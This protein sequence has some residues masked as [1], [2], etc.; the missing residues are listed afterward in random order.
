MNRTGWSALVLSLLVGCGQEEFALPQQSSTLLP[1]ADGAAVYALNVDEGTVA[2]MSLGADRAVELFDAGAE[3]TRL[4]RGGGRV[5]VTLRGERSVVAFDEGAGKLTETARSE[6]GAEP[7]G[8]V[9]TADGSRVYVAISMEDRVVEL[10]GSTL[11]ELRTWTVLDEPRWLALTHD[12]HQ[13]YV[14]SARDGRFTRIDLESGATA[15]V[16]L[17][18]VGPGRGP[19]PDVGGGVV[20]APDIDGMTDLDLLVTG[21]PAISADG[22][23]LAIPSVYADT[24]TPVDGD[25]DAGR[26]GGY[27]SSGSGL[28]LSRFNPSLILLPLD[29]AG[30]PLVDEAK[31]VFIGVDTL[32]DAFRSYPSSATADTTGRY[33]VVPLEASNVAVV[34]DSEPF[35]GQ[36]DDEPSRK[37]KEFDGT[38][39]VQM[40]FWM[41][42][43]T[44]VGTGAGPRGVAIVDGEL[45]IHSFLD[46]QLRW[47]SL[48]DALEVNRHLASDR[49]ESFAE[50]GRPKLEL[51]GRRPLTPSVLPDDVRRGRELFYSA[52]DSNVAARN[53]GVSCST[54]HIDGRTDG[55]S[56]PFS[57]G[58]RQTP[59]LAGLVSETAPFAWSGDVET[60]V[61]EAFETSQTRMGGHKIEDAALL[62]I[63]AFVDFS[64]EVDL[65]HKGRAD[66]LVEEGRLLF[67]RGDVGCATCHSGP[68][69]T[70]GRVHSV[71]DRP[72]N[73]PSLTGVAATPPYLRDGSLR[74]LTALLEWT[75]SGAMG[76]TSMLDERQHAALEAYLRSL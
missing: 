75:D 7:F 46:R 50:F 57:D 31:P 27:A 62:D 39:P 60:V 68:R 64:R 36:R 61:D 45:V 43:V 19:E 38:H 32:G 35:R 51:P 33:F 76:D 37:I 12:E 16:T 8:V 1:S 22:R 26:G 2:R 59:S 69:F 71:L 63:A 48:D 25:G 70:D 41:R 58:V 52:V 30:L 21:D 13:L 4:S 24:S 10:D 14:A 9:A 54:C 6:V 65:P 49:T 72:S 11:D 15:D 29:E 3:P 34:V 47:G 17:P 23:L 18:K 55:R 42:P 53:G 73:T 66:A 5:F 40:G 20:I 56:W 28:A 44:A 74:D 67:E